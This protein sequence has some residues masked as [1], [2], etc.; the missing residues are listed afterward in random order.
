MMSL[1]KSGTHSKC[2][3]NL[4]GGVKIKYLLKNEN[5][6]GLKKKKKGGSINYICYER[7]KCFKLN[8]RGESISYLIPLP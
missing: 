7:S 5:V 6:I 4:D 2:V 8:S 1:H 3:N